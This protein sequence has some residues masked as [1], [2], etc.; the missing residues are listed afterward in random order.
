MKA[1]NVN[2]SEV[3]RRNYVCINVSVSSNSGGPN[4]KRLLRLPVTFLIILLFLQYTE[5]S[6]HATELMSVAPDQIF[7]FVHIYKDVGTFQI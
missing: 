5:A 4:W 7:L 1:V 2:N 3:I 6:I